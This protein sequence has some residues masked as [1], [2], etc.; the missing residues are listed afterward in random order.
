MYY[1]KYLRNSSL[2]Q[3]VSF[4]LDFVIDFR[5]ANLKNKLVYD[6]LSR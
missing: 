5:D 1:D 3:F 4:C 6:L 2:L